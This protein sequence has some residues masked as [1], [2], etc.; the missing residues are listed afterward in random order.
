[1]LLQVQVLHAENSEWSRYL[2]MFRRFCNFFLG[3][4]FLYAGLLADYTESNR[5]W[6]LGVLY[7]PCWDRFQLPGFRRWHIVPGCCKGTPIFH[8]KLWK[9]TLLSSSRTDANISPDGGFFLLDAT[10]HS[11]WC[12]L[13]CSY[14]WPPFPCC[15][16]NLLSSLTYQ[17]WEQLMPIL[18]WMPHTFLGEKWETT[19]LPSISNTE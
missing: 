19:L 2:S 11:H 6:H 7:N 13:S 14:Q 12:H 9:F 17:W 1:M 4:E 10:S 8:W 3:D 16:H 15:C 5:L 18:V